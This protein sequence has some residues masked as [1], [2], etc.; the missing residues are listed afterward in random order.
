MALTPAQQATLTAALA[1]LAKRAAAN[2]LS[3]A[4]KQSAANAL[5]SS[6]TNTGVAAQQVVEVAPTEVVNTSQSSTYGYSNP[7]SSQSS[8]YT[9]KTYVPASNTSTYTPTPV[10]SSGYTGNSI[11]DYLDST[12]VDSS[13]SARATLAANNGIT[14]YTGTAAQNTA[15][16]NKL[17]TSTT[18]TSTNKNALEAFT[19]GTTNF[20][21]QDVASGGTI[22]TTDK[23]IQSPTNPTASIKNPNYVNTTDEYI[24]SP[25]NATASIKNPNYIKPTDQTIIPTNT[26]T[27]GTNGTQTTTAKLP[28]DSSY[29]YNTETGVLNPNYFAYEAPVTQSGEISTD[30]IV[31]IP[32]TPEA[33]DI[34]N[35]YTES[36]KYQ[37]ETART[38]LETAYQ[39][40]L[41]E[42][43]VREEAY[44]AKIS[45]ITN[46]EA[47][48]F[49]DVDALTEPFREELEN[50]E[51]ERLYIQEN[52]DANQLLVKELGTLLTEGN[53][54]IEQLSGVTGLTSIRNARIN[55]GIDAVNARAGVISAVMAAREG[56]INQAYT[57]ID[58]SLAAITADKTDKLA[59]YNS[60]L[61]YYSSEKAQAIL[62]RDDTFDDEKAYASAQLALLQSDIVNIEKT[63]DTVRQALIDPATSLLYA[64]AGISLLDSPET[65]NQKL[66][67]QQYFNEV[68]E[69][70]TTMSL[71]GYKPLAAGSSIPSGALVVSTVDSNGVQR[72]WYQI[73]SGAGASTNTIT[74]TNSDGSKSTFQ[75]NNATGKYDIPITGP[76]DLLGTMKLAVSQIEGLNDTLL[77]IEDI[78]SQTTGLKRTITPT[79]WSKGWNAVA[80]AISESEKTEFISSINKLISGGTLDALIE[81]KS[82]GTSFGALSDTELSIIGS[83]FSKLQGYKDSGWKIDADS[84]INELNSIKQHTK[85]FMET[86]AADANLSINEDGQIVTTGGTTT[87]GFSETW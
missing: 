45:D 81:K 69:T 28:D 36:L 12:G 58:R 71:N 38:A 75:F 20:Y 82:T 55:Q 29:K 87:G 35:K 25:T 26:T 11:V 76:E 79:L 51:R 78:E 15:L 70:V 64:Q 67:Q 77:L 17:R 16:L 62:D 74:V 85:R 3:A 27:Y 9:Q 5:A 40:K 56:Q 44:R 68:T 31:Y 6:Q 83:S 32:P 13:Y 23:Y 86:I 34:I 49:A 43:K 63:A 80:N 53:T 7:N 4:E 22:N 30:E 52:F 21:N 1:E 2:E 47:T 42:L 41:D 39:Q 73:S 57:M 37:E 19:N 46:K 59:Y 50:T 66:A 33:A 10:V 14:N 72:D 54:L 8:I 61:N 48:A 24:Q 84:V 60:L 18:T 65:I